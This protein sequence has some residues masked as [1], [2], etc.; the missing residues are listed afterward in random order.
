VSL[1]VRLGARKRAKLAL[2]RQRFR[3]KGLETRHPARRSNLTDILGELAQQWVRSLEFH[4]LDERGDLLAPL[5]QLAVRPGR[6]SGSQR[7]KRFSYAREAILDLDLEWRNMRS[8]LTEVEPYGKDAVFRLRHRA[9]VRPRVFRRERHDRFVQPGLKPGDPRRR[10]V[11]LRVID[12]LARLF[13]GGPNTRR[14]LGHALR[15][16]LG[17][18]STRLG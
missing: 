10:K 16:L 4:F 15:K 9:L 14:V 8:C 1:D 2:Q 3:R 5:L 7:F 13:I 17:G 11:A 6:Q 18:L 12:L